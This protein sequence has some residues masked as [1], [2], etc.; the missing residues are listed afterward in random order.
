MRFVIV[1]QQPTMTLHLSI[2][3]N[4]YTPRSPSTAATDFTLTMCIWTGWTLSLTLRQVQVWAHIA[5]N[6]NSHCQLHFKSF[7][8]SPQLQKWTSSCPFILLL[9]FFL[10]KHSPNLFQQNLPLS[11]ITSL[12]SSP[13]NLAESQTWVPKL[14]KLY[15]VKIENTFYYLHNCSKWNNDVQLLYENTSWA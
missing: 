2:L 14:K 9:L 3:T 5:E 6:E 13:P 8:L 7:K 10:D 1:V 12:K 15:K 11:S 4:M